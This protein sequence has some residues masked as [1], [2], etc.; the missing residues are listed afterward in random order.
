MKFELNFGGHLAGRSVVK[1]VV[2][3]AVSRGLVRTQ[4]DTALAYLTDAN[5]NPCFGYY[6]YKDLLLNRPSGVP[7]HCL[8]VSN[9]DAD[10]QLL[11][12]IE[13]F[14]IQRMVVVLSRNYKGPDIHESYAIDP[15]DGTE[16]QIEFMLAL[17]RDEVDA[18][19]RYER[20][21]RTSVESV[22]AAVIA[23]ALKRRQ[24][25]HQSQ[26]L[27]SAVEYAFKNCGASEGEE[28]TKEQIHTL[29]GLVVE[30]LTPYLAHVLA[31]PKGHEGAQ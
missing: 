21:G 17:S 20:T 28:L 6:H 23:P 14:G 25:Q 11:G 4:C 3:L 1:S 16:L 12:Y 29:C 26:V 27:S 2:C 24:E 31:T 30:K 7:L 9:K 18:A 19:F 22:A 10:G 15:V 8:A 5:G 13:L